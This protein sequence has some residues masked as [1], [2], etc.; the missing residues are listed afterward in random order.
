MEITK[1][2]IKTSKS[3]GRQAGTPQGAQM[4]ITHVPRKGIGN[5]RFRFN[6]SLVLGLCQ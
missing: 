6:N 1:R 2:Q 5:G 3:D 4:N